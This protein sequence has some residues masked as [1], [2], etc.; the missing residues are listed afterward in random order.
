MFTTPKPK[1]SEI[2]SLQWERLRAAATAY[3]ARGVS[4]LVHPFRALEPDTSDL[5]PGYGA[6]KGISTFS[7]PTEPETVTGAGQPWSSPLTPAPDLFIP[8]LDSHQ[9]KD[10]H[11][12][13]SVSQWGLFHSHCPFPGR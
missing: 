7:H 3:P 5:G 6:S 13:L 11:Y 4:M 9:E 2:L 10:F 8:N 1:E 12:F